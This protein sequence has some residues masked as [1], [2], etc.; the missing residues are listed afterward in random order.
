MNILI[1]FYDLWKI[2]SLKKWFEEAGFKQIRFIEIIKTNPVS[3]N[4]K[5]NYL[6][7]AREIALTGVKGS[8]PSFKS[9]YDNGIYNF[10]STTKKI[11]FTQ[12]QNH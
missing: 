8:K 3:I 10:Q 4:S 5:L 7:N 2:F 9:E 6:T 11:V 1:C 12:R